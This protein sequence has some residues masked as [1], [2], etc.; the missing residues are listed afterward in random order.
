MWTKEEI[1][2]ITKNAKKRGQVLIELMRSSNKKDWII[3]EIGV[4]NSGSTKQILRG[5]GDII[6]QYWAVDFWQCSDHRAYR[7]IPIEEWEKLHF[8]ACKL[9]Y[10]F[11]QL[12]VV[13][14]SSLEAAKIF[15]KKYFDLVFLD[16]DHTYEAVINDIKAWLPLVKDGGL[17]T[18]HDHN[19][20]HPGVVKAVTD[21]FGE[22]IK[23]P[24]LVWI[25]K[26]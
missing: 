6:S 24:D 5:C 15:P 14:M 13:R 21:C 9:M 1:Q 12:H 20:T 22:V 11:P 16:A 4:W 10:W 8:Y 23:A 19:R 25:K 18:G 2:K 26:L 7:D 3:A 17:L